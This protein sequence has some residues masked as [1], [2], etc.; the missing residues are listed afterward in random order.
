MARN[1][2]CAVET[3]DMV[4][5]PDKGE[6]TPRALTET[7]VVAHDDPI[8]R[9]GPVEATSSSQVGAAAMHRQTTGGTVRPET[10]R[11]EDAILHSAHAAIG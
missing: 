8:N 10:G 11:R 2:A 7:A 5:G 9:D 4:T 1:F 6:G 3:R